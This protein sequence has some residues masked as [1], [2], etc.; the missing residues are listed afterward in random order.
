MLLIQW[1]IK[2]KATTIT[3]IFTAII[4]KMIMTYLNQTIGNSWQEIATTSK[5]VKKTLTKPIKEIPK[6]YVLFPFLLA[7]MLLLA[8]NQRTIA[9]GIII[10]KNK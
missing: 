3:E 7:L 1:T 9:I 8:V 10:N 2:I 6:R 4:A 5:I